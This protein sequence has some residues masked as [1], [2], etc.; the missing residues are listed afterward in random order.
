MSLNVQVPSAENVAVKSIA[1]PSA[2]NT[3]S[4]KVCGEIK[5]K[6]ETD[7]VPSPVKSKVP[8][9]GGFVNTT[10]MSAVNVS[11]VKTVGVLLSSQADSSEDV[12]SVILQV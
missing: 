1:L 8:L 5:P 12:I 7:A 11:S 3:T 6:V 2:G 10:V 4:A 9:I